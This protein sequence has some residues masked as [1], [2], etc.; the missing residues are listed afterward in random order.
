MI[1]HDI[2]E[3][4]AWQEI[5]E[6]SPN[7]C[8]K[9][10]LF[11]GIFGDIETERKRAYEDAYQQGFAEGQRIAKQKLAPRLHAGGYSIQRTAELL[12]ISLA[13]AR[14]WIRKGSGT[15]G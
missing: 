9:I 15:R 11:E 1:L 14:K 4:K 8:R 7:E 2:R 5:Q 10:G 6:R 12:Y 3:S 13:E